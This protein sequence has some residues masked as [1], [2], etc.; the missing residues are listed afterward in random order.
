[1]PRAKELTESEKW[2]IICRYNLILGN[3]RTKLGKGEL[4]GLE[5]ELG[6]KRRTIIS[7]TS[8]YAEQVRAKGFLNVDMKPKKI[9]NVG[10]RETITPAEKRRIHRSNSL[11][12]GKAS[13]RKLA[14]ETGLGLSKVA[15]HMKKEYVTY[16]RKWIK[17]KLTVNHKKDR[18]S[19]ILNLKRPGRRWLFKEQKNVIVVDESWFYLLKD[20]SL[21][22]VYPGEELPPSDKV[23]HKSH[24]PK[25]MFL[26]ALARPDPENGFDGKI[27]IWRV[28]QLVVC[29][30]GNRWHRRGDEYWKDC[31]MNGDLYQEFM[32][33]LLAEIKVKMPWLKG[34][35][36]IVQQDG[37]SAHTTPSNLEVFNREGRKDG[38]KIKV[39]TQP[40]QSPDLNINDLAF[41][42]SLKCRVEILKNG[43]ETLNSLY[44][45]VLQAWEEYDSDTLQRI[46][47]V[48]Y[49]CY[50]NILHIKG[51]NDY[52]TPH[53][54]VRKRGGE[55][56]FE[57][58]EDEY[59]EAENWLDNN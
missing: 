10:R 26:T 40:A 46:W 6:V 12:K 5:H 47:G 4:L 35:E 22:R 44:E 33:K 54:G 31:N 36:V 41:F 20:R 38:W 32:L 48:Q 39:I 2:A 1:M 25:L 37:A 17:P 43:A 34:K 29:E 27:G 56:D 50:R 9:G 21:V 13:L 16:K 24:I 53:S 18:I 42:R 7:I 23:Q 59:N 52:T 3:N 55:I 57:I 30:R 14:F 28:Q 58:D 45:S 49:E 8:N 51:D 19:F 15:R 11:H